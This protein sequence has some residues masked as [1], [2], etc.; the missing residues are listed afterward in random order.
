M[1]TL[2][3]DV[4]EWIWGGE[5]TRQTR[6]FNC[7]QTVLALGLEVPVSAIE[8]IAGTTERMWLRDV[9]A[10]FGQLGLW[11]PICSADLAAAWWPQLRQQYGG[12][13]LRGWG[14]QL[15]RAGRGPGHAF[16]IRGRWMYDPQTGERVRVTADTIRERLDRVALLRPEM[17]ADSAVLAS[18]RAPTRSRVRRTELPMRDNSARATGAV[19]DT[20]RETEARARSLDALGQRVGASMGA[21]VPVA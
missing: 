12:W 2:V 20:A 14:F 21:W 9:R 16:L 1:A 19:G 10:V 17:I 18:L 15:P 11:V 8:R 4:V 6:A 7:V 3:R 13:R 5:A